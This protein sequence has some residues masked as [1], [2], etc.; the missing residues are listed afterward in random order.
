M[1][2]TFLVVVDAVD[3]VPG[4]LQIKYPPFHFITGCRT[5]EN[6]R[7]FAI[8]ALDTENRCSRVRP[9]MEIYTGKS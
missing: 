2:L 9:S 7:R 5:E 1:T 4:Q 8:V 3:L 6:Q